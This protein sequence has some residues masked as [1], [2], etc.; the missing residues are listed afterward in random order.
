LVEPYLEEAPF[1]ELC[2]DSLVVGAAP[3]IEHI[4][5]IC[6]EP[7]D[8]SPISSPLFPLRPLTCMHSMSPYATFEDIIPPWTLIVHT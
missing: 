6:I 8:L 3:I 4:D 5:P 1:E 2:D 7:L